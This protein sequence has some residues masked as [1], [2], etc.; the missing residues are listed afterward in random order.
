M[1]LTLRIGRWTL[2]FFA[3]EID[4]PEIEEAAVFMSTTSHTEIAAGF[5]A[6]EEYWEDEEI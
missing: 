6:P 1:S 2:T 3:I 4:E 5:V